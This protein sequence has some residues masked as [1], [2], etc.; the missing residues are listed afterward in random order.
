MARSKLVPAHDGR[1][2][3]AYVRRRARRFLDRFPWSDLRALEI[4][5]AINACYNSQRVALSRVYEDLGFPK[6]L[7]RSSLLHTLFLAG[8]PL[9]HSEIASEL[10]ITQGSV[11]FLVD[12]LEKEGLVTRSTDS[13]DR[14]IVHVGLTE[15]GEGVCQTITPAVARLLGD[16]CAGLSDE[17]KDR[18]LD[19]LLRFLAAARESYLAGRGVSG[20]VGDVAEAVG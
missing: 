7:G 3:E 14:R 11:T 1:R 4:A 6:A 5:N 19:L 17:E 2:D 9:T 10:E 15:K 16:L 8:R 13:T 20:A 18:L 12:G